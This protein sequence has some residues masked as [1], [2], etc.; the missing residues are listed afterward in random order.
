MAD[1]GWKKRKWLKLVLLLTG[2]VCAVLALVFL[3]VKDA[4]SAALKWT[5]DIGLWGYPVLGVMYVLATV[6]FIPGSL[7]TLAAGFLFGVIGGSLLVSAASTTGAALAFLIGRYLARGV[8][9]DKVTG[10]PK[11]SAI[12]AAVERQGFKMVLLTRLSPVF[13]FNLLNYAFG[14]TR[15]R[16]WPYVLAS[17]LGMI[18]GTVMYVY[19]GSTAK[20]LAQV[21]SGNVEGGMGQQ[22]L[23]IV[24]LA[25][26]VA[27]T[28]FVTRVA[29]KALKEAVPE[30]KE[31]AIIDA[32]E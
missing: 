17:W 3:P 10:R 21:F 22:I 31:E 19:L 28:V 4:I 6:L 8:V 29:R 11:F 7:L 16:F 2:I 1:G 12:D 18:P 27:V 20:D 32:A 5:Q 15:V 23:K 13:P 25:A 30:E 24:G 14:L 26:T 9:E